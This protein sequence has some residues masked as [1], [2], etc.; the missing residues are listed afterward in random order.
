[1]SVAELPSLIAQQHVHTVQF[2]GE[3]GVLLHE[4]KGYLG[5]AL[6]AGSSAIVIATQGHIAG[7]ARTLEAHDIDIRK[8]E[9]EN[10]YFA[11]NATEVMSQLIIDG[12]P[13]PLRFE[14]VVG[15][16]IARAAQ[17]A[18]DDNKCVVAF[19]EMVALL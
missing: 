12:R 14:E 9:A 4:L 5:S 19:G 10:R 11:L 17:G 8:A 15:S 1:M 6:S 2:Y 13:D 16:L 18:R 7:L 3:D